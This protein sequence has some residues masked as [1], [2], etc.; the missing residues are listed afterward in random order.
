MSVVPSIRLSG[1]QTAFRPLMLALLVIGVWDLSGADHLLS[2]LIA[3]SDA[4]FPWRSHPL[5]VNV[6][7][8][9]GRLLAVATL[10]FLVIDAWRAHQA[11]RLPSGRD[12]FVAIALVLSCMVIVSIAKRWSLTSCPWDILDFGGLVPYVPHWQLDRA[13]GGPGHCFPSGHASAAFAFLPVVFLWRRHDPQQARWILWAVLLCGTAFGVAQV[14]RG[15]HYVSHVLWTAWICWAVSA[16]AMARYDVVQ[17]RRHH[18]RSPDI[19]P[20][21]QRTT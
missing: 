16:L 7:H 6:F 4:G 8:E 12:R 14:L 20:Q 13:D 11:G 10:V 1:L 19:R 15:A 21:E 2:S 3:S 18:G 9:G 17:H 5:L